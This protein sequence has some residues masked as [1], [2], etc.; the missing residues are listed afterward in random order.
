MTTGYEPLKAPTVVAQE[1]FEKVLEHNPD[2]DMR[3]VPNQWVLDER[4]L[5][6]QLGAQIDRLTTEV[7][8][9]WVDGYIDAERCRYFHEEGGRTMP[10]DTLKNTRRLAE[11]MYELSQK[12]KQAA[13]VSGKQ[14]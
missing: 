11:K 4:A 8:T 5:T 1:V 14:E 2:A 3:A 6:D 12:E 7:R 10:D 13:P 9:A